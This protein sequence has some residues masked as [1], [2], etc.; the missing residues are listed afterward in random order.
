[1]SELFDIEKRVRNLSSAQRVE[2]ANRIRQQQTTVLTPGEGAQHRLHLAAYV[3]ARPDCVGD[4]QAIRRHLLQNLPGH[5][6]PSQIIFLNEIPR[7]PNGKIDHQRLVETREEP[8]LTATTESASSEVERCLSEI[9][10]TVLQCGEVGVHDNFFELGG[11]SILAIQIVSRARRHGHRFTPAQL[12]QAPT[13]SQLARLETRVSTAISDEPG[14]GNI[15]GELPLTPIQSWFFERDIPEKDHYNQAIVLEST[16]PLEPAKL[17]TALHAVLVHHDALRLRFYATELG[18]HQVNGGTDNLNQDNL[19]FV[20]C[21]LAGMSSTEQDQ[22]MAEITSRLQQSLNITTGP[23]IQVAYFELGGGRPDRLLV[24]IHHLATDGVASRILAE[25]IETAYKQS[26]RNTEIQLPL[27]TTSYLRWAKEVRALVTSGKLNDEVAYWTNLQESQPIPVDFDSA[28][29]TEAGVETV[30]VLLEKEVTAALLQIVP[31]VYNTRI[32]EILLAALALGF[33]RWKKLSAVLIEVEH[34]GREVFNDTL[35][36]SRTAGWFTV[37]YPFVLRHG[38]RGDLGELI[39]MTKERIRNVP[40]NGIGYWY[41]RYGDT[42]DAVKTRLSELPGHQ[43]SFNYMG[44]MDRSA[45]TDSMLAFTRHDTGASY[46]PS[47]PRPYLLEINSLIV[48]GR[49]G[50]NLRYGKAIH[51]RSTVEDLCGHFNDSLHEIIAHC[52]RTEAGGYT[53]SDFP[54]VQL[55]QDELDELNDDLS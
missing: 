18:W 31:A 32:S 45:S 16:H 23:L 55:D 20:A 3:K 33:Y 5:M 6:I 48:D 14:Q 11:D 47:T 12:V 10:S 40:G 1:M 42:P 24:I 36:L 27:K 52:Q 43:V 53:P 15:E 46:S 13:I 39:K 2:L 7:M 34:H 29:N 25:D 35:D 44:Q 19:P 49:L 54:H 50:I 26:T 9:W 17:R 21:P 28:E 38:N 51:K 37:A 22:E 30:A 4:P 8:S 41:L